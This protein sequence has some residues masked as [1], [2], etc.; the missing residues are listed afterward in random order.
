[1]KK[2]ALYA[3][4]LLAACAFTACD[5]D[6]TD[7]AD[8]QQNQQ[9]AAAE[10]VNLT[11]QAVPT[12]TIDREQAADSVDLVALVSIIN[13]PEGSVAKFSKLFVNGSHSLP[14]V[15]HGGT[16]RVAVA[17]LDSV[18]ELA[19]LSRQ[20]TERELKL[21][22]DASV[23]TPDGQSLKASPEDVTVK[24]LQV[25]PPSV[26]DEYYVL[27]DFCGWTADAAAPMTDKGNGVFELVFETTGAAWFKFVPK[28]G[29]VG[30]N[31]DWA[32]V[33]GSAVDS[34]T[35]TD[36]FITWSNAQ[37]FKV[38]DAAKYRMTID[39]V[40]WR[41][42][43]K[44]V[45]PEIYM[46]GSAYNWNEWKSFVPVNGQDGQF[47]K[48]VYLSEGEEFKF[49]P[50]Q[51]WGKDFGAAQL[52]FADHAGAGL[53]GTNNIVVGKAGWYLL[54]LDTNAMVLE[55]YSPDVYLIGNTAGSWDVKAAN[56]FSVPASKDGEFVSPAF[57][58]EDDIRVCVHP[59][60]AIEW[61]RMEFIVL[62]GKIVFR[63][64]DGD[65]ERVK[66]QTGQKLYLNFTEGTGS[67][68]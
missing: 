35:S 15:D 29:I 12:A 14:F 54:Y 37:A 65:Q 50:E 1:M 47:W 64:N 39:M 7:W 28:S 68:K 19:Y 26:E 13:A 4:A 17:Q 10:A 22:V 60:E 2:L 57:V 25:T 18:V 6:F 61:W 34:D 53:S 63:G 24:Y 40:N 11:M 45:S 27:G 44:T 21:S 20:R 8:P 55:T 43:I 16:L 31:V 49:A 66:G 52:T 59:K 51:G 62:D 33:C 48:V 23:V 3:G 5:E 58:A 38:S 41:Y 36:A 56:L 32:K 46:T 42:S 9:E 67:I 30:G